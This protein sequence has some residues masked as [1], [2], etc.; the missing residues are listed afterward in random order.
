MADR[1]D[2]L[3]WLLEGEP[4][5]RYRTRVDLLGQSEKDADAR[6]GKA[7]RHLLSLVRENGWPCAVSASLG[8][9]RGPGRRGD[10]CP[11]ATFLKRIAA[12]PYL[13]GMA[14]II[15]AQADTNGRFAAQSRVG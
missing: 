13:F 14:A 4:W 15:A 11:Y 6:A 1:I 12:K 9:F 5:V 8:N 10:P 3:G 7:L 2:A